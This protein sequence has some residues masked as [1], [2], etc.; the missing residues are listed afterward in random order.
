[1][2]E[3]TKR[4]LWALLCLILLAGTCWWLA[5]AIAPSPLK[6]T[7]TIQAGKAPGSW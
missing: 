7:H 3:V 4:D 6:S 5:L 1:M 2:G